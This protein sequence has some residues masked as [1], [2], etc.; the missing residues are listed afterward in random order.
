M[1]KVRD[2]KSRLI[3]ACNKNAK[4]PDF[5]KGQQVV[6]SDHLGVSQEAVRKWFSGISVP[7]PNAMKALAHF[8]DV[9]Y[10]WLSLGVDHEETAIMR[11]MSISQDASLYAFVSY[12]LNR[13]GTVA[14]NESVGCTSD[15]TA[16]ENGK[17]TKYSVYSAINITD[18]YQQFKLTRNSID[19][20]CVCAVK[21]EHC[22]VAYNFVT[23]P[24]KEAADYASKDVPYVITYDNQ[25]PI[26]AIA[27]E[28]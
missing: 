16:I 18:T 20:E 28:N 13:G 25:E 10:V 14:F 4:I 1:N 8:L 27:K 26:E 9:Q 15:L 7:R 21:I 2:F 23:V 24:M 17:M 12:I 11:K 6:I 19:V 3:I 22:D 5:G